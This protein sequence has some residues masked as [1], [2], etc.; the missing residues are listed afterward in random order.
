MS[1]ELLLKLEKVKYEQQ[2]ISRPQLFEWFFNE[3]SE[4]TYF[5]HLALTQASAP[6]IHWMLAFM[7]ECEEGQI[8][9]FLM[10][11]DFQDNTIGHVICDNAFL[12]R[13]DIAH[14]GV[15]NAFLSCLE[16]L[17]SKCRPELLRARNERGLSLNDVAR[18]M[19]CDLK[20]HAYFNATGQALGLSKE[21]AF[22]AVP[23]ASKLSVDTSRATSGGAPP[24]LSKKKLLENN[25][26]PPEEV[27]VEAVVPPPS[28]KRPS[29]RKRFVVHVEEDEGPSESISPT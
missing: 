21:G 16:K 7:S 13:Q 28:L 19:R 14:S 5:A 26:F 6:F 17:S 20:A 8:F 2:K 9:S 1:F 22:M 24:N 11:R 23:Q 4:N 15:F 10:L 29:H 27:A 25:F 18:L 3:A 12:A